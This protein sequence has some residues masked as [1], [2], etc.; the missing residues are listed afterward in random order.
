MLTRSARRLLV[1][2]ALATF[3]VG[4][5]LAV[6]MGL[7]EEG[8]AGS[9]AAATTPAAAARPKSKPTRRASAPKAAAFVRLSGAGAFDPEGDDRERDEEAPLAV[10]GREDTFWRTERYSRFF[11]SG[12]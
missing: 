11:K 3:L 2:A 6:V 9:Q 7:D 5:G 4:L 10:D 12:V 8:S 1:G